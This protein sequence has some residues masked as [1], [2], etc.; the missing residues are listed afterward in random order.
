MKLERIQ[1]LSIVL[2][3]GSFLYLFEIFYH[4]F[5]QGDFNKVQIIL[6]FLLLFASGGLLIGYQMLEGTVKKKELF[7]MGSFL[8]LSV[9]MLFAIFYTRNSGT[10]VPLLLAAAYFGT[11]VFL[12]V[13]KDFL[14]SITRSENPMIRFSS[15]FFIVLGILILPAAGYEY[16]MT[17]SVNFQFEAL[18]MPLIGLITYITEKVVNLLG[19][20][21]YSVSAIGGYTLIASDTKFRVF[22]GAFCSGVT[23]M[24]VFIAA[25]IAM[26]YDLKVSHARKAALFAM[27]IIGT[28]FANIIRVVILF[29][30][31]YYYGASALLTVHTHLGWIIFFIWITIFWM[32]ALKDTGGDVSNKKHP[33]RY[34]D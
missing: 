9:L 21:V 10:I 7:E 23:S 20:P 25:F 3:L 17:G 26:S 8:G 30:V 19:I 6:T 33:Y 22:V 2:L 28:F 11:A 1:I 4:G 29:L 32:I 14:S 34:K 27:G 24:A 15:R 13:K 31:G 12:M 18:Y 16:G 5:V